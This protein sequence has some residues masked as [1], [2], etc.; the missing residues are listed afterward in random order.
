MRN[1]I[2]IFDSGTGG[3]TVAH[4][5]HRLLPK[6]KLIYF[7]DTLHLPYGE[8]SQ[9][10]IIEY[11][12]K[13]TRF[14]IN[15]N[16]KVIVIACNTAT[17]QAYDAIKKI[18]DQQNIPCINVIHP[19]VKQVVNST[20]TRVGVIGTRG[21]INT[22]AYGKSIGAEAPNKKVY[23]LA[24]PLL[25]P[26]IEEGIYNHPISR[27]II[28]YYL[29]QPILKDIET[30]ILGCTHYPLLYTE[31][32]HFYE[33]KIPILDGAHI[34]ALEVQRILA[35]NGI[36]A[37]ERAGENEFIISDYTPIFEK[38]ARIF[39]QEKVNLTVKKEVSI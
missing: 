5:I 35:K 20:F 9:E 6:E 8:K 30:L 32:E 2:G 11:S 33:Y 13:I 18:C 19:V 39:F 12:E 37:T 27:E 15:K 4:A 16:A 29:N 23:S 24:T 17:A 36:S 28:A 25:V 3:L 22:N 38:N 21:T 34:V 31:I 10:T 14:L 26:M 1:N 7:G